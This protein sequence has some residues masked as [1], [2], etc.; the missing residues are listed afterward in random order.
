MLEVLASG[1]SKIKVLNLRFND[2]SSANTDTLAKAINKLE[3]VKISHGSLTIEQAEKVLLKCIEKTSLT[4]LDIGSNLN[5]F[6]VQNIGNIL[7]TVK[8]R[9]GHF[10]FCDC[11]IK[12]SKWPFFTCTDCNI[13]FCDG[14]EKGSKELNDDIC[15][16]CSWKQRRKRFKLQRVL[17]G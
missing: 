9:I 3:H 11:F 14:C 2:L 10:R 4:K 16:S 1:E 12:L 7:Q 15:S 8:S 5:I 6:S 17:T 13:V